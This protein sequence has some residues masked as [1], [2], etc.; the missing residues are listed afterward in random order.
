MSS[1]IAV[2]VLLATLLGLRRQDADRCCP[3]E[4]NEKTPVL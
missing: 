2:V 1:V 4:L 3:D